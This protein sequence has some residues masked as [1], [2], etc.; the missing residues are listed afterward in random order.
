MKAETKHEAMSRLADEFNQLLRNIDDAFHD[1]P[2]PET[3][4]L[5]WAHVG[6]AGHVVDELQN[7]LTILKP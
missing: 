7:V 2:A 6:T 3:E 1:L 4:A 5:T